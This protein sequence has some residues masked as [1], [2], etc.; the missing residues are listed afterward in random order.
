MSFLS[1][2]LADIATYLSLII[3]IIF[4][5]YQEVSKARNKTNEALRLKDE[6]INMII[7]NHINSNLE[8]V[9]VD[10]DTVISGFEKL[11]S[12]KLL[13]SKKD[14]LEMIYA[15]V[16]DNEH[17]E[18]SV[19]I[20]ILK[21]TKAV[22]TDLDL[23]DNIH[24]I[25][26]NKWDSLVASF[27]ASMVTFSTMLIGSAI[28]I[29][30][31][32][33]PDDPLII[34]C[35]IAFITYIVFKL[36]PLLNNLMEFLFTRDREDNEIKRNNDYTKTLNELEELLKNLNEENQEVFH[37]LIEEEPLRI[38]DKK[39]ITLN[40]YTKEGTN[41]LRIA[42]LRLLLE[43]KL[44]EYFDGYFKNKHEQKIKPNSFVK[45]LS[46]LE[47]EKAFNEDEVSL[48]KNIY[49]YAS[50]FL[51][52]HNDTRSITE[53]LDFISDLEFTI[54]LIDRRIND[55]KDPD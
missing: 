14:L 6:F 3:A 15:K 36:Q 42:E 21:Q 54:R 9:Q 33:L 25:S 4:F 12:C 27:G 22:L 20:N 30:K 35:I 26:I 39:T 2:D 34:V 13:Y 55:L 48:I 46:L 16:S 19:R 28:V 47:S 40:E 44:N 32:I 38:E 45:I 8:I 7:R 37:D 51:H 1:M 43:Y 53:L 52:E 49:S 24:G 18:S 50:M 11:K 17:I 23:T 31:D 10:F 29:K 41:I 5:I